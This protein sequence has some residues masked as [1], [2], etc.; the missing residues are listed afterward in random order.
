MKTSERVTEV[1]FNIR[2]RVILTFEGKY[3]YIYEHLLHT[4]S[5]VSVIDAILSL[6]YHRNTHILSFCNRMI[7]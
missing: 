4:I 6:Q 3:L 7:S 1:F 2:K 5:N